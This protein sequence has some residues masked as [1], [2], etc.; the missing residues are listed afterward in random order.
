M[1]PKRAA[2]KKGDGNKSPKRGCENDRKISC[3]AN[4]MMRKCFHFKFETAKLLL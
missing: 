4:R 2:P 1:E 3:I